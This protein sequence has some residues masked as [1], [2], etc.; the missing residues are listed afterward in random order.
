[1]FVNLDL[2]PDEAQKFWPVY[3][4]LNKEQREAQKNRLEMSV[5]LRE[6]EESISDKKAKELTR[7]YTLSKQDEANLAVKYNEEFLKILPP[8]K[9]LKLYK[10]E[11][12]FRMYLIKKF[13]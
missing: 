3:N 11:N 2:T 13:R 5:K 6:T 10:V 9:V 4:K 7:K 12:E 1:M 8:I